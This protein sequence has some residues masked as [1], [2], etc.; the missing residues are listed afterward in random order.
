MLGLTLCGPGD[1]AWAKSEAR[2]K[3]RLSRQHVTL[4]LSEKKP[5]SCR[6][7]VKYATKKQL[8]KARWSS[9]NRRVATVSKQGKVRAR[10]AGKTVITVKLG[11]RRLRCLVTVKK[12]KKQTGENHEAAGDTHPGKE[13]LHTAEEEKKESSGTGD[14]DGTAASPKSYTYI[15]EKLYVVEELPRQAVR[16]VE[17][18]FDHGD[19]SMDSVD[20]ADQVLGLA[21]WKIGDTGYLVEPDKT[22]RSNMTNIDLMALLKQVRTL[23]QSNTVDVAFLCRLEERAAAVLDEL[24]GQ[25]QAEQI[26]ERYPAAEDLVQDEAFLA[27]VCTDWDISEAAET[28]GGVWNRE[29]LAQCYR[30]WAQ[31]VDSWREDNGMGYWDFYLY[32]S[33]HHAY[34][35][36]GKALQPGREDGG[37]RTSG[38]RYVCLGSRI[39]YRRN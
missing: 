27:A 24:I 8:K 5:V 23:T 35:P 29:V 26:V 28:C 10:K 2:R 9:S 25:T 34:H 38:M 6:L 21:V 18:Y 17:R 15:E 36:E 14:D 37:Y 12:A 20:P 30:L 39:A 13:N 19:G 16:S 7:K 22:T 3:P 11:K 31:A 32:G 4:H 33:K 1:T